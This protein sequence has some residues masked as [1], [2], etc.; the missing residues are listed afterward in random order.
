MTGLAAGGGGG[1][2]KRCKQSRNPGSCCSLWENFGASSKQQQQQQADF[3]IVMTAMGE[4]YRTAATMGKP[5]FYLSG[6][7]FGISI[8]MQS[9]SFGWFVRLIK[10]VCAGK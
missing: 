3:S 9:S 7:T 4:I 1:E 8:I 6:A 2:K 5:T 10:C